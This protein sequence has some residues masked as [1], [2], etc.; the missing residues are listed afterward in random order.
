METSIRRLYGRGTCTLCRQRKTRCELP[1]EALHCR[2]SEEPLPEHIACHRCQTLGLP[3]IIR[4][5]VTTNPAIN[6]TVT[7]ITRRDSHEHD[8]IRGHSTVPHDSAPP[9]SRQASGNT[10][11]HST[12]SSNANSDD[13]A[14]TRFFGQTVSSPSPIELGLQSA[15]GNHASPRPGSGI[16]GSDVGSR[17][18]THQA[19]FS[20]RFHGRPL[21]LASAL[22]RR[23]HLKETL[24]WH[25]T[26]SAQ[27]INGV[28]TP[29]LLGSAIDRYVPS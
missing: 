16:P 29:E 28:L 13:R 10:S 9:F 11:Q 5:K 27:E 15:Y 2:P 3:C 17:N 14:P 24:V 4:P 19:D 20:I 12:S 21:E 26:Q 25:G 23:S 1:L 22:F 6:S 8:G 7:A 18:N